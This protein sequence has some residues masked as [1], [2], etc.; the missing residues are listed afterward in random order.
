MKGLM[1]AAPQSTSGKTVVTC[2]I[3]G[4]LKKRDMDVVSF[5]CGPD[6]IDPMFHRTVLGIPSGNLDGFFSDSQQLRALAAAADIKEKSAIREDHERL[7]IVE[8]VMGLYDGL[9]GVSQEAS[10][11]AVAEALD[12][13]IVLVI[14]A[15]GM[16]RTI[17]SL[18]K[19]ILLDDTSHL[20]RGVILNK[21]SKSWYPTI[22]NLI[23]NETGIP[24]LGYL[25]VNNDLMIKSRHLGLITPSDM[26][27]VN[28]TLAAAAQ[29]CEECISIDDLMAL[30]KKPAA[31]NNIM[32]KANT[33]NQGSSTSDSRKIFYGGSQGQHRIRIAVAE[34]EAFCFLYEENKNILKQFGA[35]LVSF[36]PLHDENLPE[37]TAGIYLCGG[38]PELYLKQLSENKTM[39]VSIR[40][41]IQMGVPS[42]AEC[43]GFLYLQESVADG[44]G[45]IYPL[46]GVLKGHGEKKKNLVRFGYVTL[47]DAPENSFLGTG[48]IRGHEFHYYD[49][50]DNGN[51]VTA[52]KPVSGKT[53]SCIHAAEDHWWGFPHLYY[54]NHPEFAKRFLNAAGRYC[55][56]NITKAAK[57]PL[58]NEKNAKIFRV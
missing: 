37:N 6:Y 51:D 40:N 13:P 36:S 33:K 20:I 49:V 16:G 56:D 52:I 21:I 50:T 44:D 19:G 38:Y 15:R 18:L 27:E 1:I 42:I 39:L 22:S 7:F 34:D 11:Y 58:V 9:G 23:E 8:G 3:L 25:P 46:C 55:K 14:N 57:Q 43:G 29:V 48:R 45:N 12:I 30:A 24:V 17:I 4:A 47:Q 41:A 35:E 26:K 28:K 32:E 31:C 54:P 5:K 10:S 53:W 2:G